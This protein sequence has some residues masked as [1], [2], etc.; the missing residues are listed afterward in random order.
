[1]PALRAV[2]GALLVPGV[3]AAQAAPAAPA[4]PVYRGLTPGLSYRA[5]VERATAL[6]D[7]DVLVCNTSQHT[8]YLMECGVGIRDP[9]DGAR[10]YL[11]GHFIE[12]RADVIALYD[13][14]GF[15]DTRGPELVARTQR[16]LTRVLGRHRQI[17][18][19]AWEWNYG[20]Q[21]VRLVWRA[22]G[23]SRWVSITLIDTDVINRIGPY[24][25]SVRGKT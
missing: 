10:F 7:H 23:A 9:A 12:Q 25:K 2:L 8:A 4:S 21:F 1:M 19:G 14:A 20:H 11:S 17:H 18:P 15:H 22:R 5:F 3:L 24:R 13:S 16:D 6:A